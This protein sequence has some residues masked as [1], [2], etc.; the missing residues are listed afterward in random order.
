MSWW[1]I[2]KDRRRTHRKLG[3]WELGLIPV[4]S[5]PVPIPRIYVMVNH[6]K[7]APSFV[8][9]DDSSLWIH[10]PTSIYVFWNKKIHKV[11]RTS[12]EVCEVCAVSDHL[13]SSHA[14]MGTRPGLGPGRWSWCKWC[15]EVR[16]FGGQGIEKGGTIHEKNGE[17][18]ANIWWKYGE[19]MSINGLLGGNVWGETLGNIIQLPSW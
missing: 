9:Q 6:P 3:V 12:P 15:L 1:K 19:N 7:N 17:N 14:V 5:N 18:M 11:F 13:R 4:I 8:F 16:I 2:L 10:K